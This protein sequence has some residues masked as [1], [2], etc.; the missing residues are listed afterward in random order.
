MKKFSIQGQKQ[1]NFKK[2]LKSKIAIK[3]KWEKFFFLR[4]STM[5]PKGPVGFRFFQQTN[6]VAVKHKK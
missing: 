3:Q 6:R 4:N 2:L 1:F 5:C